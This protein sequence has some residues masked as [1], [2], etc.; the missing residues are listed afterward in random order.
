MDISDYFPKDKYS[1][2]S[3]FPACTENLNYVKSSLFLPLPHNKIILKHKLQ[4]LELVS[5]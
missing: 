4:A 1:V 3:F 2:L 5:N